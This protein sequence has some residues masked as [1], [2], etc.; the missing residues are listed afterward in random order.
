MR[1]NRIL[2]LFCILMSILFIG[3]SSASRYYKLDNKEHQK[4]LAYLLSILEKSDETSESRFIIIQQIIKVLHG[5]EEQEKLNLFL[6]T[7]V[8]KNLDD[9]FNAYYLLTVALNY[10]EAGAYPFAVHYFERVLRNFPDILV[11]GT[12]VHYLCLRNLIVLVNRPEIR[13]DYY[14]ELLARFGDVIDKGPTYY[15]LARTYEELGEW[16]LSIQA[17]KNYLNSSNTSIPGIPDAVREISS[18]ISFFDRR[19]KNWTMESL[20]QL[21]RVVKSAITNRDSRLLTRY[22]AKVNFF[23]TSWE[24]EESEADIEFLADIGSFMRNRIYYSAELESDSNNREAYLR[25]W[26]WSYRI[27]T[28]YL[29]FR[30]IN[31]PADPEIHGEWE[32]AGIYFGEKPFTSS[33]ARAS[34]NL[35]LGN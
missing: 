30:K 28:W 27:S 6:T 12:S 34:E 20:D 29:Y 5:A 7:Q 24:E 31:F 14:K 13:V 15:Y 1:L 9:P 33:I 19:D 35:Y 11:R 23:A 10:K 18:M 21:I 3:C 8:Q 32:W 2:P 26:G 4:E 25:T 22:R 17:Y 16:D